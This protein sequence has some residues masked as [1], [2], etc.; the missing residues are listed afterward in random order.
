MPDLVHLFALAFAR[1]KTIRAVD[2]EARNRANILVRMNDSQRHQHRFWIV[3]ADDQ[4]HHVIE[5]FGVTAVVPHSKLEI[6]R[7][8]EAEKI[9]L[10]YVFVRAARDARLG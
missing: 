8:N 4:R 7:P 9:G 5:S 1:V 2:D 3:F 6:R 10:V